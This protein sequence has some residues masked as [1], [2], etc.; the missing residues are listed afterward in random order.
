M[1]LL[2]CLI[3]VS[4][5]I[6]L[7]VACAPLKK[8]QKDPD[9]SYVF[10]DDWL[11]TYKGEL[12][13]IQGKKQKAKIP[14]SIEIF[15]DKENPKAIVWRTT[16][17]STA[18]F[19]FK[20]V[21]NYVIIQPD[22]LKEGHYLMDEQNGIYIDMQLIDN[23]FYSCFDVISTEKGSISRIISTD[24][25]LNRNE[26]YHKI[27]SSPPP[28]KKSGDIGV[29]KGYQVLSSPDISVQKAVL[30]RVKK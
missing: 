17:D 29:S 8:N 22:S 4:A 14:I 25:L 6:I 26:L 15:E 16:Y 28:V 19:P 1:K 12:E 2:K 5:L 7:T 21:K 27:I 23:C 11:G 18:A 9:I 3:L 30:R 20:V 13:W 24:R 10:P